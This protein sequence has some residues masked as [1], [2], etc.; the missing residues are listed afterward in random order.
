MLIAFKIPCE[1]VSELLYELINL[2]YNILSSILFAS[3]EENRCYQN[4]DM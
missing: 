4:I 1:I 3:I 2:L